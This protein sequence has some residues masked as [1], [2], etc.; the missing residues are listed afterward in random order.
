MNA[1]QGSRASSPFGIV[2]DYA[3]FDTYDSCYRAR[4]IFGV[5]SVIVET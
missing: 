3:G 1:W 4:Q 2:L 5:R